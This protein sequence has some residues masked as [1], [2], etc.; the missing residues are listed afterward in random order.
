MAPVP[1]KKAPCP[2]AVDRAKTAES[3]QPSLRPRRPEK[4]R[5][6]SRP[7]PTSPERAR[8][9]SRPKDRNR[10]T[11]IPG[12]TRTPL[13]QPAACVNGL[14]PFVETLHAW[15]TGVPVD[16]G[17]NWSPEHIKLAMEKGPHRSALSPES[18]ELVHADVGYQEKAGFARIVPW[19]ELMADMPPT[20]KISPLAVVP[21][22]NR[23][24]R[25]ILDLSF[26]V[27]KSGT[28]KRRLGDIVQESVNDSTT[29]L[30]PTEPVKEL[31]RVLPRV[32]DFMADVPA[33]ETILFSKID[34]S[35]GFW[36]MVV[37]E[38]DSYNFAYVLPDVEGAPL[39]IVVPQALQMG[40]TESPAL[41]CSATDNNQV[42]RMR[43]ND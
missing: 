31:G 2:K 21:Q 5:Q 29:R 9:A 11:P 6:A 23:R 28:N 33:E 34:L 38:A 41:F 37:S 27:H 35:D 8:Q 43:D 10:T 36:R 19:S 42:L 1:A 24:G 30:A 13:M 20:L 12:S 17:P 26:A 32:L 15:E 4:A 39:R 3:I 18:I 14:H 25:M 7:C 40:W 22:Q 16:C